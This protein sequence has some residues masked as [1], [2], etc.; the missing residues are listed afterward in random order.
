MAMSQSSHVGPVGVP[1]GS[2]P[3]AASLRDC[4]DQHY[5]ALIEI[6][7]VAKANS[8]NAAPALQLQRVRPQG[9]AMRPQPA[10]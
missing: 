8:A 4:L 7:Q 3:K 5:S 6:A 1:T 10:S 2:Q 9:S